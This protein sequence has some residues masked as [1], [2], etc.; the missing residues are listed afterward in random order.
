MNSAAHHDAAFRERMQRPWYERTDGCENNC[1]IEFFRRHLVRTA[2]P[3]RAQFFC[4][5][6]CC[7]VARTRKHEQFASFVERHLRDQMRGVAKPVN[8]EAAGVA[9]FAIRPITDQ[10]GAK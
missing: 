10:S 8:T 4:G 9:R 3:Y 7:L 6:L 1:G 2:R 5:L